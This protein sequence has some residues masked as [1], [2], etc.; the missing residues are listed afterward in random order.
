[1]LLFLLLGF[2]EHCPLLLLL[3]LLLDFS[4]HC[5]LLLLLLLLASP[6]LCS[7]R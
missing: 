1:M 2:S 6:K 4:E 7:A 3:L 5:P